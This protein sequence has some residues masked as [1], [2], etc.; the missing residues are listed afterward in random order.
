[1]SRRSFVQRCAIGTAA[2]ASGPILGAREASPGAAGH[3]SGRATRV[4]SLAGEWR[5]GGKFTPGAA[6]PD[7][8][9][10]AFAPITLP[11]AVAPQSWQNWDPAQWQDVW[12]YRRHFTVPESF[13]G[14]RV[15]LHFEG[16]MTGAIPTLNGREL[17]PHYGG[18]LP[19]RYEV[20][21]WLRAGR[22]VLALAVDAR[23]SPVP[24][25][26]S[27][28]GPISVDYLQMGGIHRTI[29]LEAVPPTYLADVFAQPVRVLAADRGVEVKCTLDAAAAPTGPVAVEVELRDGDRVLARERVA[30]RLE[31]AGRS[32][33]ALTLA[34]LGDVKLWD[35]DSPQLYQVVATLRVDGRPLHD[36]AVRIGFR[37]ARFAVD[38]FFL[39]GRRLRL[40]GLNRHEVYPY[41]GFAMPDRV[42]R[43]D[44]E[45]LRRD[46]HCNIVRCSHYPQSPAFLDACDELG[47]LV[48]EEVPG[49]QYIG[50]AAWKR[51]VVRDTRDMILRDRNR[52]SVVIWGTRI[53]ESRSD[54]ELYKE[55]RAVARELDGSR[56]TSGSMTPESLKHWQQEWAQDVFAFDDYH[57][58]PDGTVGILPPLPGVPYFLAETVGQFNYTNR[59]YF[60]SKYRRAGEV[61]LQQAQ[62]IR[63]AQAHSKAATHPR[64]G[65]VI[66]WCAF[67]YSSL[68][69][70]FNNLKC[71]GVADGF[72]IPKL[73]GSFYLAQGDPRVRPVIAPNFF[74]DFGPQTPRGPGKQV[75]VFSNCERLELF[76]NGRPHATLQPDTRN[77]PHLSHAP[78]FTDLDLDGA[79]HPELRIDG[80]VGGKLALSRSF[81]ADPAQDQFLLQADDAEL[82]GDGADA[83]RLVFKV[84]DKFGA[85]RAFGG[86]EVTMTV[87]GPATLVGDNPFALAPS[88]GV[89]AVWVRTQPKGEGTVRVTARHSELGTRQIAI[90]VKRA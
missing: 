12:I 36:Y 72:R 8:G 19:F 51:L 37:E 4:Q 58:E 41:V 21:E 57:A 75:A 76:L 25:D 67:D 87:Q 65:G 48:W 9:D 7:F 81:S 60:T 40:F 74:W 49:W 5:F 68:V 15:F 77:Y 61:A 3:S 38:G 14:Q 13:R 30:V 11:H 85:D 10:A 42:M 16:V 46:F 23:W 84:V 53:N 26:G 56:P 27:A 59:K 82:V 32:E 52:P 34:N 86:G 88:G 29:R 39:N 89:G 17:P 66:A 90:R 80:Y 63:H 62:A 45:I 55:T 20:T 24:P 70:P 43:R 71:P 79:G 28:K 6:A 54:V 69:N 1:M 78:F 44:A 18:Y 31:K 73:G 50:D 83:T 2:L 35:V 64:M 22:N 47:L 33:V